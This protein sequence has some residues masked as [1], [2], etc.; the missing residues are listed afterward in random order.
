MK[1]LI[2]PIIYS[3]ACA[4]LVIS[5]ISCTL[6]AFEM[7]KA[8]YAALTAYSVITTAVFSALSIGVKSRKTFA[9]SAFGLTALYA[10]VLFIIRDSLWLSGTSFVNIIL[11]R[12][13]LAYKW[14]EPIKA[15]DVDINLFIACLAVFFA[16]I[17]TL[18]AVR[19]RRFVPAALLS[20]AAIMP[21][22]LVKDSPPDFLP[23]TVSTVIILTMFLVR[24]LHRMNISVTPAAVVPCAAA[25]LIAAL[26]IGTL[27]LKP[28]K[29]LE[30]FSDSLQGIDGSSGVKNS[31][32]QFDDNVDL[33]ELDDLELSTL[34]EAEVT[35][36]LSDRD[37]YLKDA[38]YSEFTDNVWSL[39]NGTGWQDSF[40]EQEVFG[41]P[42]NFDVEAESSKLGILDLISRERSL[43]PYS[44]YFTDYNFPFSPLRD[45][46]LKSDGE[47][48]EWYNYSIDMSDNT[49]GCTMHDYAL[50]SYA[51]YTKR[52]YTRLPQKLTDLT[53]T[54]VGLGAAKSSDDLNTR[55]NAV[56]N[57]FTELGGEY[58]ITEGKVPEGDYLK[59][60]TER[61]KGWCIH[62]ATAAA[63]IL[64][65]LG[66][67][68]RYVVGYKFHV[69]ENHKPSEK[70]K[71]TQ[72]NR[73]AWA[74]YYDVYR[75]WVPL[76]V[77][78]GQGTN[79]NGGEEGTTQAE[80]GSTTAAP[81][82]E[83]PTTV[84][85]TTTAAET[86]VPSSSAAT[87]E[88]A[89][90]NDKNNGNNRHDKSNGLINVL[91][92]LMI[93]LTALLAALAALLLR[94]KLII[95][96]LHRRMNG[97]DLNKSAIE[98]YR[99]AQKLDKYLDAGI[100]SEVTEA[101]E[102]AKF[103]SQGIDRDELQI[104]RNY[105][106]YAVNCLEEN[107]SGARNLFYKYIV[108]IY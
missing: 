32:I 89:P 58:S 81:T 95:D 33:S 53:K 83:A 51:G 107:S 3:V 104:I 13:N 84:A 28:S 105:C 69:D 54:D 106:D 8:D 76:D 36:S 19:L 61:K 70:N 37:I 75:G 102:K 26:V 44:I 66:V 85:P 82:T 48:D 62:Y 21:C 87:T 60:F 92:T 93:V 100:L 56:Y 45:I 6:T 68:S 97:K 12:L 15:P 16:I 25:V 103:S 27:D 5:L 14:I 99:Y 74:E 1:K 72:Q 80:G 52:N 77:T 64:R 94:R 39:N 101:A 23:L 49:A 11:K 63:L 67:P 40:S 10:A 20:I 31:G 86:T 96:S 34:T 35:T 91:I 4:A 2:H 88:P 17:L 108:C 38:S 43:H 78:P 46:S 47:S 57:Y 30:R 7:Q 22:Y 71:L 65:E 79:D 90:N 9:L 98:A 18:T 50:L 24:F 55:V 29:Q 59:W 41:I 42:L 73:H